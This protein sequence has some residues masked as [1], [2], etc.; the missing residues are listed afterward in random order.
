M[1]RTDTLII[2]AGQAGLA[3]S[4]L[5]TAD[6]HDH[7]V[8][9]RGRVGER[10]RSERWA[11]LALLTPGWAN[12]LP[13]EPPPA[14][15]DGFESAAAFVDRLE[16]YARSFGAPVR[17]ETTAVSV[18][19]APGGL[20]VVTDRGTWHARKGGVASGGCAVPAGP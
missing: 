2:G 17:P 16:R 8:L 13:G 3:L 1:P 18:S 5:L 9:E 11:S 7:I 19:R 6:A 4:H 15:P 20:R 10:W 12:R 14:D